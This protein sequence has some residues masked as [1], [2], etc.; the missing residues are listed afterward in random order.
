MV[1]KKVEN[2]SWLEFKEEKYETRN[3]KITKH[4]LID[5]VGILGWPNL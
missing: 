5:K 3:R 2:I 4:S 1:N